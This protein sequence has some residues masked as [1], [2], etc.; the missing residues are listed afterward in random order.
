VDAAGKVEVSRYTT[1]A[2]VLRLLVSAESKLFNDDP[3][4]LRNVFRIGAEACERFE[5]ADQ[6]SSRALVRIAELESLLAR[7]ADVLETAPLP[8]DGGVWPVFT[9]AQEIRRALGQME[10]QGSTGAVASAL[11]GR[12]SRS[13]DPE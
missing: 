13:G 3:E 11:P 8:I 1:T 9:L 2:Q 6:R 5:E 4:P 12:A 10:P 7:V